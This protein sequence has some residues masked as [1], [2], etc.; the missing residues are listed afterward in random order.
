VCGVHEKELVACPLMSNQK[1]DETYCSE[2]L[3]EKK[4]R[5]RE[6]ASQFW[7][8]EEQLT[9]DRK[10]NVAEQPAYVAKMRKKFAGFVSLS[11][12][13]DSFI[14]VA[15]GIRPEHQR[16]GIGQSLIR[17]AEV[18]GI[19]MHKKRILVSTSNDDLPALGF[20]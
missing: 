19:K 16:S 5:I 15:L 8:E 17:Q 3:V 1:Q 13:R 7:R 9:F 6:L 14:V 20:Y 18:E 10:F 12:N 2:S 4:D 11:E